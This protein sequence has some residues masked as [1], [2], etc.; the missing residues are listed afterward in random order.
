MVRLVHVNQPSTSQPTGEFTDLLEC[1]RMASRPEVGGSRDDADR[2][3]IVASGAA[4]ASTSPACGTDRSARFG[5]VISASRSSELYHR[6]A[7]PFR[8]LQ[9][10]MRAHHTVSR[11]TSTEHGADRMT[12]SAVLPSVNRARP[13]RPWVPTTTSSAERCQIDDGLRSLVPTS[14]SPRHRYR[15][16]STH[17]EA[18]PEPQSADR[19]S[20]ESK[21]PECHVRTGG[22]LLPHR[23][24]QQERM[25]QRRRR[26]EA[27][28]VTHVAEL[29]LPPAPTP[30]KRD[31]RSP[32]R[33]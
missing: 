24:H 15:S 19:R 7:Y 8:S 22:Q 16:G 26:E 21:C 32:L 17:L 2:I 23:P 1:L 14:Q 18:C 3:D 5:P 10:H 31:P 9:V 11:T 6:L 13:V 33:R 30:V 29:P 28:G 4:D 12:A 25:C 27:G 20:P